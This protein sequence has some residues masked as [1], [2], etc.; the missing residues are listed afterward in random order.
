MRNDFAHK[1][2]TQ[3]SKSSVEILYSCLGA[4]EKEQVQA[5]FNRIKN[6]NE[7]ISSAQRF[8]DLEPVDQF[9]LITVTLWAVAQAVVLLYADDDSADT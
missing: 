1:P 8:T 6:T 7:S 9:K 3:L 5:R 4:E 2:D